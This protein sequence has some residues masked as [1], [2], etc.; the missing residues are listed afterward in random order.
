MAEAAIAIVTTA[1]M[2][3]LIA[4]G[5]PVRR[6]VRDR[7]RVHPHLEAHRDTDRRPEGAHDERD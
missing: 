6:Q 7:S 2:R 1:E 5:T 4:D 3:L